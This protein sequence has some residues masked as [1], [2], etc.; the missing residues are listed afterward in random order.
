MVCTKEI[1]SFKSVR[2]LRTSRKLSY[3]EDQ[4][5]LDDSDMDADYNPSE[6]VSSTSNWSALSRDNFRKASRE[7]IFYGTENT[8]VAH[9]W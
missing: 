8:I 6:E 9:S 4:S 7:T 5:L 3:E 1:E 2:V